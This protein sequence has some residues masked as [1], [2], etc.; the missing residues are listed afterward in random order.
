MNFYER[1]HKVFQI[2]V[3]N[4]CDQK[5]LVLVG[6]LFDTVP[7]S[8]EDA[9]V[10]DLLPKCKSSDSLIAV[11]ETINTYTYDFYYKFI[12]IL[13]FGLIDTIRYTKKYDCYL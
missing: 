3:K 13:Y 6:I 7:I 1:K 8:S 9:G 2:N 11:G 5:Y 10:E 4:S 12:D